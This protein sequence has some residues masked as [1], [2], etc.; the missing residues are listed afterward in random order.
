MIRN[1]SGSGALG[2]AQVRSQID[3]LNEDFRAIPETPGG[4]GFDTGIQFYLATEDP[5][6]NPTTGITFSTNNTWYRDSGQYYNTLA[7]D[8]RRYLNIYSNNGG[9]ALGYV[10]RLPQQGGVGSKSDRVVVLWSTVGRN[11]PRYPFN[12]GRTVTHEVGHYL[13]LWHTFD[14]GCGTSSCYTTGDAICDTNSQQSP[15]SGCTGRT[16]CGSPDP[17]HNY[18][19]YSDDRCMWEFTNEQALRMRCTIE[20]YR[21]ALAEQC[22]LASSVMRTAGANAASLAVQPPVVGGT[23][24]ARIDPTTTGH[25]TALVFGSTRSTNLPVGGG[26]VLLADPAGPGAFSIAAAGP[27][28]TVQFPIP[29]DVALCGVQLF[30]QAGHFGGAAGF[31]LS[32]AQDLI[33]G[34]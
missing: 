3:I 24:V 26:Y 14:R 4:P 28:A 5:A 30:T 18:M 27:Q 22:A 31:A 9:G 33:V 19:D 13:G 25:T 29:P 21:S 16:S 34:L 32:N 10:P 15:T 7:W 8:T 17:F 1:T 11:A 2:E 6:G 23:F 12:M 20:N